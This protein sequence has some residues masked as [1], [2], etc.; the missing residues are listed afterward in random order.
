MSNFEN[1]I[2][3]IRD[4]LR[5]NG[6]TAMDSINHCILFT[7]HRYFDNKRCEMLGLPM[8]FSFDLL[9]DVNKAEDIY[10]IV[11]C[12]LP[13]IKTKFFKTFNW[14]F[15]GKKTDITILSE[16]YKVLKTINIDEL[17]L[18]RDIIGIIYELHLRSGASGTA[19]R[20]LGQ[21]FTH[22][23]VISYMIKLC[24]PK[25]GETIID[26]TM[27]TGG[28]LTMAIKFL[29]NKYSDI[30]WNEQRQKVI[31]F[32]IDETV[33][34]MAK[35]NVF[36]ETG[37]D[38]SDTL[39]Q[40][41]TLYTDMVLNGL[42]VSGD[43][44]LCNEPMGLT[45]ITH[46][47]CCD[48]IKN[49]KLRG[50]KAEPLFLQLFMEALN[51]NGRCAVVVPDGV[52]FNES[53]LHLGTRK[54]LIENFNLIKVIGLTDKNFFLNTGVST[55]ILF[56]ERKGKTTKVIFTELLLKSDE[57]V[58]E[59]IL[60]EVDYDTIVK[61]NYSLFLNKYKISQEIRIEGIE[62]MKLGDICEVKLGKSISKNQLQ[63]G[64]YNVIGG[65]VKYMGVHNSYNVN[66]K[67]ITIGKIGANAGNIQ[68]H[69]DKLFVT[70]NAC[71][72]INIKINTKYLYYILRYFEHII[73]KYV[74]KTG[75]PALELNMVK[76]LEIPIPSMETQNSIVEQL[77]VISENSATCQKAIG[78]FKKMM[79]YYIETMTMFGEKVK[80]GDICE[81]NTGKN[82][83]LIH[84]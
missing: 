20:D 76:D 51:E 66:E 83:S 28:F 10:K 8:N 53:N 15:N 33:M 6:I 38:F 60:I 54:M 5:R 2:N 70:S 30:D 68:Y 75:Q 37:V 32:D 80:L 11:M 55:S 81:I 48:R 49:L 17:S 69:N 39:F 34:D 67:S 84:I 7:L 16:I 62:Y 41:D 12:E 44:L 31:G 19:M 72:F 61:N 57:L 27:G 18:N 26:P 78:E 71:Y 64:I 1:K 74:T 24:D 46:A 3:K 42:E 4:L 36:L 82:L 77:D 56:F 47:N 35:L 73:R 22:R 40:R 23:L 25:M 52:L 63:N 65:G 29:N 59:K 58:E 45:N 43:V 50:T 9:Q 13:K 79:K 14:K 21:Y